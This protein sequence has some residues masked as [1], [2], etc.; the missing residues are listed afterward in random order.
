[1][2][3]FNEVTWY[4]KLAA[5]IFLLGIF[6]TLTFYIGI[7]YQESQ[8][9]PR[10]VEIP[11]TPRTSS[12]ITPVA[13]STPEVSNTSE[14]RI[15]Q[16]QNI[17]GL[18]V[19]FNKIIQDSRCPIDVQ[20]IQAGNVTASIKLQNYDLV[21]E[22]DMISDKIYT[23]DSYSISIIKVSPQQKSSRTINSNEYIII[24]KVDK[25]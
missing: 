8:D 18:Q 6:P 4:S 2:I 25:I 10:V 20:C 24:V 3:K 5:T 19:T 1:M 22:L 9:I 23:F 14:L 21:G 13:T 15:Q 16:T 17:N 11:F 7:K 12:V